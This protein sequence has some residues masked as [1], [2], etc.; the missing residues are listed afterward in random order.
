[1]C[2]NNLKTLLKK[3]GFALFYTGRKDNQQR[4]MDFLSTIPGPL[5]EY[6]TSISD[7]LFYKMF[8]ELQTEGL[9]RRRQFSQYTGKV[10]SGNN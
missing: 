10:T 7:N 1:M 5:T 9:P 8:Y 2:Y 6:F 4:V 3:E